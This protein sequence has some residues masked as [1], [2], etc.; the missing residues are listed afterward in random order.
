MDCAKIGQEIPVTEFFGV[1]IVC[2][3]AIFGGRP[4][5]GEH[6]VSVHDVVALYRRGDTPSEIAEAFSLTL[7][8]V[9]AALAYYRDHQVQID[10][11]IVEDEREIARLAAQD[12]SPL[13]ERL[14]RVLKD[15]ELRS[16]HG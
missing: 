14:R 5:V 13:R 3:P 2:D 10:Y 15:R 12:T 11:E 16:S 8:E 9:Q 7:A 4:I 1:R 6:R